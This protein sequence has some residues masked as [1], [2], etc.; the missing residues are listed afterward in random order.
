MISFTTYF[1]E[2]ASYFWTF[3]RLWKRWGKYKLIKTKKLKESLKIDIL[4]Y[5]KIGIFKNYECS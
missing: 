1:T 2:L 3:N 5:F 4:I